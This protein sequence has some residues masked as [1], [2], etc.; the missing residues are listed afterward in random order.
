MRKLAFVLFGLFPLF[1]YAQSSP[2][3]DA[4]SPMHV[5]VP[6][7]KSGDCPKPAAGKK[8]KQIEIFLKVDITAEGKPDNIIVVHGSGDAC[9]DKKTVETVQQYHFK[10]ATKHGKPIATHTYIQV[11]YR[12]N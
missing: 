9:I 7:A 11:G 5:D 4:A 10:P 8:S 1:A 3:P 12:L 6:E 2:K